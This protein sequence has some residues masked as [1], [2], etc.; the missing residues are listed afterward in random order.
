MGYYYRQDGT[1]QKGTAHR[2]TDGQ[3]QTASS[4]GSGSSS[5]SSAGGGFGWEQTFT[6]T[7]WLFDADA[8]DQLAVEKVTTTGYSD[9]GGLEEAISNAGSDP[10]VI[11]FEVGGTIDMDGTTLEPGPQTWI[12]GETAPDPGISL[13]RGGVEPRD[14]KIIVS[15]LGIY[16]GDGAGGVDSAIEPRGD[17]LIFDH[18]SAFWGVDEVVGM[19]DTQ[20]R[21]S[22]INTIIAEGLDESKHNEGPHSRGYL[23]NETDCTELATMGCLIASNNRRSPWAKSEMVLVNNL[24]YNHC[25]SPNEGGNIIKVGS[26]STP[27]PMTAKGIYLW[28][29][30]ET[31]MSEEVFQLDGDLYIDDVVANGHEM[32]DGSQ[33]LVDSPPLLPDGLS[34]ADTT[35]AADM[36][37]FIRQVCGMRPE[38]R[39]PADQRFFTDRFDGTFTGTIDSQEEVGGYPDY[40][41]T[42]RT[43]QVPET[44]I[45]EWVRKYTNA[46]AAT[47]TGTEEDSGSSSLN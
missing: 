14:D 44:S 8:N 10:A 42:T 16:A 11:V 45:F 35:A 36:P 32:T 15:H 39:P 18:C 40:E 24:I 38:S 41:T 9:S 17:D 46:V 27:R 1:W 31:Q 26:Y 4:G 19:S 22:L 33:D 5:P 30:E 6:D 3:F 34:L 37:Q 25:S 29:T 13:I 23:I 21:V 43:L 7:S 2:Q 20:H 47:D 28:P 12:A